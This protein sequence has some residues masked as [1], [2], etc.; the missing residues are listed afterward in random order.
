VVSVDG[1]ETNLAV[2]GV[3]YAHVRE[4]IALL[5]AEKRAQRAETPLIGVAYTL[6]PRNLRELAPVLEDLAPLGLHGFH[7]Q[8]LIIFYEGLRD[9]NI[10]A[11][12][13]ADGV[14]RACKARAAELGIE[15]VVFRSQWSADERNARPEDVRVQL[16]AYS[17]RYGCSDPFY[18]MKIQ[19][20]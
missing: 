6:M 18:E 8:P 14:L 5:C 7:I 10:Y 12:T 16:G 17:E 4:R 1:L 19:Y 15:M 11:C 2:R 13:E 20:D 3:P 9:E